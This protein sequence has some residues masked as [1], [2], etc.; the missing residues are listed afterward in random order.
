MIDPDRLMN[1]PFE[2]V[3]HSYS[4]DFSMLYALSVGLGADPMDE[5]QLRFTNDTNPGT[6]IALPTMA[7]VLGYPG[8]W[9]ADPATG[10]DY[11][12]NVHGEEEIILH[13]VLPAAG[14]VIARHRVTDISDKGVGKGA[15]VTY[16][17]VLFDK[18]DGS[19]LATVIHT[20]FLRGQGGFTKGEQAAGSSTPAP[21]V[22]DRSPDRVR[23]V[24][25]LPQQALLYRLCADRNPLHSDPSTAAAAGFDRP[26]LHGLGTFGLA[27][28]AI[29]GEFCGYAPEQLR[30]L[31]ARFSSP[32]LPGET[33]VFEMFDTGDGI[34]FQARTKERD[35]PVLT[36]G[37]AV[38]DR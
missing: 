11:S 18:A 2:E 29:L 38:I 37:R 8:A 30:S 28:Q 27:G 1:W 3:E 9:M 24:A 36:H 35:R 6:P 4:A 12:R 26:I 21:P 23:E 20:T 17:K 32:V 15:T 5:R 19:R 34:A 25:T 14:V 33:L 7:V 22:P 13:K 10:I 16:E 31:R